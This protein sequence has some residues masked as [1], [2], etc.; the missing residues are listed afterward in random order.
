MAELVFKMEKAPHYSM[1]TEYWCMKHN[2]EI[3]CEKRWRE[4]VCDVDYCCQ[5]ES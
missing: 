1:I 2:L 5:S 4:S 3:N